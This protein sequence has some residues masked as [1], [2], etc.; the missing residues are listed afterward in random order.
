MDMNF[1]EKMQSASDGIPS[2]ENTIR[3]I[4]NGN[5]CDCQNRCTKS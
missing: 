4:K 1:T 2:I 3:F 5:E